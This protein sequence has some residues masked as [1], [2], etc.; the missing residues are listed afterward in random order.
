MYVYACVALHVCICICICDYEQ[1]TF[2]DTLIVLPTRVV[3]PRAPIF[4]G[5]FY[6][7]LFFRSHLFDVQIIVS[8][9]HAN[10]CVFH[11]VTSIALSSGV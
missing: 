6:F 10:S 7:N 2:V 5:I 1:Y 4:H 11:H 3:Y 8:A 9:G